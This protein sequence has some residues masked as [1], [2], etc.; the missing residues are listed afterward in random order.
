MNEQ[1]AAFVE[2]ASSL[3]AKVEV[4]EQLLNPGVEYKAQVTLK[5]ILLFFDELTRVQWMSTIASADDAF[6][7]Q[8][9]TEDPARI[10][11]SSRHRLWLRDVIRR[12]A[13]IEVGARRHR[14]AGRRVYSKPTTAVNVVVVEEEDGR[15]Q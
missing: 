8:E 3:T 1:S 7:E 14:R 2:V 9:S 4:F 6:G 12:K 11:R 15:I 5:R 13:V 10:R